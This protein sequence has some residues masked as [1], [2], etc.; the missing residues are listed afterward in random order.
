MSR[1]K[2]FI[3]QSMVLVVNHYYEV[4]ANTMG[5]AVNMIEHDPQLLP[6]DSDIVNAEIMSYEEADDNY[7]C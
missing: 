3:E 7:D 5:Q 1:K 2:F 4:E 6:F